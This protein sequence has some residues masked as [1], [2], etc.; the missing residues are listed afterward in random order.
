MP[1]QG[2]ELTLGHEDRCL[3]TVTLFKVALTHQGD[4]DEKVI[5]SFSFGFVRDW[6]CR[7]RQYNQHPLEG[8]EGCQ[9]PL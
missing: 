7:S 4:S 3:F 6:L 9:Y 1:L 8:V 2:S 5:C